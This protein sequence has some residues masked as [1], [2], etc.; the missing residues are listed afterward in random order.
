MPV[1]HT[2]GMSVAGLCEIC[3]ENTVEHTCGR[4]GSLV[5]DRHVDRRT[6]LCVE[7]TTDVSDTGRREKDT[8]VPETDQY[9]S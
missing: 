1:S 3:H 4:C 9:W 6:D 8:T 5:C 2:T 7:C